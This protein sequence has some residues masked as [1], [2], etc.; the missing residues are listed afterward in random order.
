MY[1]DASP[2]HSPPHQVP[3]KLASRWMGP[4]RVLEVRGPVV[5]LELPP[6][7]G[8]I[9]PWVN[10]RRLKFF[11]QRDAEFSDFE[12][13]VTPVQGGDGALR[14]EIHRIWG[15][16]PQ[17]Q[18]PAPEYLVQWKGYDT[19]QMTWVARKTLLDD[20]PALLSAYEAAPTTAQARKSAPKRAPKTVMPVDRRRSARLAAV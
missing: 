9:S 11:E 12:A 14:Y 2:Q 17:G 16:R 15:H 3:Y 20:V 10:V 1:L 7:L 5:H 8:K 4:Y 13:P 6:E 18:L 19:A